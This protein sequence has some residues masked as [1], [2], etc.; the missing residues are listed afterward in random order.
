MPI[1]RKGDKYGI[2]TAI[3]FHH[4]N[5][6]SIKFWL[7]KCDCGKEKII[8]VAGVK[9]G[10]TKSCGCLRAPHGMTGTRIY[11]SW[12]A[13]KG[14]CFNRNGKDYKNY[15]GRGI[16]ICKEW[17]TFEN[18]YRD[19]GERPEGK[20]LDRIKNNEGYCKSNC[21]WSTQKEQMNNTRY[22]RL[23]TYN[24]KTQ[25]MKQWSEE[26]GIKYE[27]VQARLRSGLS[28]EKTLISN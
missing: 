28:I 13:M 19:M 17:L 12:D 24:G 20:T 5:E 23:L 22:N 21:K 9:N 2:L 26:L 16:T 10:R 15:G 3:K 6:N 4:K 8:Y 11:K 7:F 18:F 25:N 1:I 27:I 14:R